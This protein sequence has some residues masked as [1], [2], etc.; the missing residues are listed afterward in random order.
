MIS[1]IIDIL[2]ISN[3]REM[4]PKPAGAVSGL[5]IESVEKKGSVSYP[6]ASRCPWVCQIIE[7]TMCSL[8]WRRTKPLADGGT[9]E[10]VTAQR[11]CH[12]AHVFK[13]PNR[14]RKILLV[15]QEFGQLGG[16]H[17]QPG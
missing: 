14:P 2:K 5:C 8:N 13:R 1:K 11:L 17:A 7:M 16:V 15:D 10:K 9:L 6:K 3:A 4:S 12:S